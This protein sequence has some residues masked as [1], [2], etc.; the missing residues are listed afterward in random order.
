MFFFV[1]VGAPVM[2]ENPF[3]VHLLFGCMVVM[4]VFIIYSGIDEYRQY[5]KFVE[6]LSGKKN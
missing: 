4:S 3:A 5:R 1:V 6:G 2:T